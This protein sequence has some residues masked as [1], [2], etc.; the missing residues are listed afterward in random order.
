MIKNLLLDKDIR[1]PLFDHLKETYGKIRILEE[2]TTGFSDD[3]GSV[4][5]KVKRMDYKHVYNMR[6]YL[7]TEGEDWMK[8]YEGICCLAGGM[9]NYPRSKDRWAC[10]YPVVRN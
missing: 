10:N 8:S 9:V 1:E 6:R 7:T 4:V 2:K 3:A 5:R